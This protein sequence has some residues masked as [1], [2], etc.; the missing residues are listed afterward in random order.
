MM[1]VLQD[2]G[3]VFG[4]SIRYRALGEQRWR[5]G[6]AV[7]IDPS[8]LAFL[9]DAAF[10]VN[11]DVEILLPTRVQVMGQEAPLTLLCAGPVARRLL[12]NWPEVRSMLV[13]SI[14]ESRIASEEDYRGGAAARPDLVGR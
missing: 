13:I 1:Q 8:E 3:V 2:R 4:T 10:E 6:E 12:A 5:A 11:V 9:C 14:A 7:Q